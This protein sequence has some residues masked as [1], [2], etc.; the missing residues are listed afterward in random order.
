MAGKVVYTIKK[1]LPDF[2]EELSS[3]LDYIYLVGG[4]LRDIYFGIIPV[5]F[6]FAVSD[7]FTV[8]TF[9]SDR[10]IKFFSLKNKSFPF[11]RAIDG[12]RT[13]DFTN[14]KGDTENDRLSRDFT[15]NT[16][17]Y[18][19]KT[20]TF[21][22]NRIAMSDIKN[23]ILR[24]VSENAIIEDPVRALRA[25]RFTEEFNLTPDKKT[26]L[27]V[28]DGF[29]LLKYA[30]PERKHEEMKKIFSKRID[31][32]L[33][34]FSLFLNGGKSIN[35]ITMQF[36]N[37][38]FPIL[39]REINKGVSYLSMLKVYI[40]SNL[41]S[42]DPAE[43]F[44][45]TDRETEIL[46]MLNSGKCCFENIFDIFIRY[47]IELAVLFAL[48]RCNEQ[49]ANRVKEWANVKISGNK[50]KERF[51]LSGKALGN[52]K[53]KLMKEECRKIYENV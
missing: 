44:G 21:F 2:L 7:I 17:Y 27:L 3:K 31:I 10:N 39:G 47:G 6:D 51:K 20:D 1:F 53:K 52:L 25:V 50:L 9:L 42:I 8:K 16:L 34:A 40:V 33:K 49:T 46:N 14:L 24:V 11:I 13:F 32:V 23:R 12:K 29:G 5:D 4:A 48:A 45:L 15:I 43:V 26:A 35:E 37:S 36:E 28:K 30:Q 18:D 38:D 19:V 22:E 41:F